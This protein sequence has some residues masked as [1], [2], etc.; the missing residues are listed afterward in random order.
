MR[1]ALQLCVAMMSLYAATAMPSECT[2]YSKV[3]DGTCADACLNKTVGI[4]PVAL[5]IKAGGLTK[6]SCAS[7]GYTKPNGTKSQKA[8]PCGVITFDLYTKAST[9]E[10]SRT[11]PLAAFDE[12]SALK[13]KVVDDPVMGGQSQSHLVID[14]ARKAAR[15]FGQVKIVPFLKSPGFCTFRSS[16]STFPDASGTTG[17]YMRV[18]NNMTD[19]LTQ[20]KFQ[21]ETEGGRS[22]FKQGTYSGN[23][24]VEASDR[25]V[26]VMARWSDFDLTWRGQ[27]ISGP[28]L[29]EQL[30]QIKSIGLSTFFP[31]EAGKFDVEIISMTAK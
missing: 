16:D 23:A 15:W 22:G 29:T 26:D 19:G 3:V 18:R 2:T 27:K 14:R 11:V 28:A 12:T 1:E 31:G 8:G 5:V 4:C 10:A 24:T 20:F 9:F 17:I 30:G 13:W 21:L 25:W 7:E 6:G